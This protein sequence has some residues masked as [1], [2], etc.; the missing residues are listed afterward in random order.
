[1]TTESGLRARRSSS[2]IVIM[3][4]CATAADR[5]HSPGSRDRCVVSYDLFRYHQGLRDTI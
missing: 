3:S 5:P 2:S 1:M 4:T